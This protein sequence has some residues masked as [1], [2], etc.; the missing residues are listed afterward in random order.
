MNFSTDWASRPTD[1]LPP[2]RIDHEVVLT[3]EMPIKAYDY[4]RARR[5]TRIMPS[6]KDINPRD[7]REFVA[8][9]GLIE[10]RPKA[11]GTDY[12]VRLV[13]TQAEEIFGQITGKAFR[14]SCRRRSRRAGGG[15][16]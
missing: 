11:E 10:V 14:S 3:R 13:G 6:R 7:M 12:V 15:L 8:H 4:W 5:G 2:M 16:R 1:Q 9:A